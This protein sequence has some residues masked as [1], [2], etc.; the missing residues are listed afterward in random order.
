[1]HHSYLLIGSN[2]GNRSLQLQDAC[3]L[4]ELFVGHILLKSSIYETEPWGVSKQPTFY[5]QVVQVQTNLSPQDLLVTLLQIEEKLG[6]E[7][8]QKWDARK[9]D[10][11]I[12]YFGNL[13]VNTP[14]LKIPHAE[15]PNRRFTLIPLAEIAPDEVHPLLHKTNQELLNLC[16]DNLEVRKL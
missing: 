4:I 1:M 7:R 8:F 5:N 12:L 13:V 3:R 16:K 2:L 6:R 15:I 9:I 10:L 14:N 11:D